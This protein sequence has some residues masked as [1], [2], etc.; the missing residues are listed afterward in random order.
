MS[1]S[2]VYH[3]G[4][5]GDFLTT[6]PAMA[7][8]RRLRP[9]AHLVL[10][11]KPAFAELAPPGLFDEVWDAESQ[12]LAWLFGSGRSTEGTVPPALSLLGSALLFSSAGSA[13]F[14]NLERLG[15]SGI[16]RQDPFPAMPVPII[17][18]HLSLFGG[19][20]FSEKERTPLV[21]L[22]RASPAVPPQ[23]VAV[24]PGSGSARKN[25]PLA[26]FVSL[27]RLLEG[28]GRRVTWI[29][30]PAEE[31]LSLP[32]GAA[33]WRGLPLPQLAAALSSCE[34]YVGNDSGITHLAAAAGCSTVA[35]FGPSNPLVW[36]PRGGRV[37][38]I[39]APAGTLELM[40]E[41]TVIEVCWKLL[42]K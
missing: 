17:D 12:R 15:V 22:G 42:R 30:G 35:L 7:A 10:L 26:R 25:W 32:P 1:V 38:V 39:T 9:A 20:S 19:V 37:R 28:H 21:A 27:S 36:A 29:T 2:L 23:T 6:L 34:L 5:L 31:G 4:A 11:G 24:H 16:V 14:G 13:L 41:E 40:N 3:G 18:Y 33:V 8:W